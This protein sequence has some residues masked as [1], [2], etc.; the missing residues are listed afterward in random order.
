MGHIFLAK[1]WEKHPRGLFI[2]FIMAKEIDKSNG[3][4]FENAKRHLLAFYLWKER[5][6]GEKEGERSQVTREEEII[7][8]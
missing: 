3:K 7:G 2:W 5:K 4:G 6:L 8:K 1:C